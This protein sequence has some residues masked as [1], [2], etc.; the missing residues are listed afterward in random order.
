MIY[1]SDILRMFNIEVSNTQE[2]D[3][4]IRRHNVSDNMVKRL[5][6]DGLIDYCY[7]CGSYHIKQG[8]PD[9]PKATLWECDACESKRDKQDEENYLKKFYNKK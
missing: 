3:Q 4:F 5:H 7:T 8:K 9:W 1:Y 2:L 6:L